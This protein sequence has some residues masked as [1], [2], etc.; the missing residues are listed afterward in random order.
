MIRQVQTTL[1]MKISQFKSKP[2]PIK[3]DFG[4]GLYE[5]TLYFTTRGRDLWHTQV[6]GADDIIVTG[7]VP[8]LNIREKLMTSEYLLSKW[9]MHYAT[10]ISVLSCICR[11]VYVKIHQSKI[12]IR[13]FSHM[14]GN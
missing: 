5:L 14:D 2:D 3:L 11:V 12:L 1:C 13:I 6:S 9:N 7:S 4:F 8:E 10:K